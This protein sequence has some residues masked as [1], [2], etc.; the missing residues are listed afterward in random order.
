MKPNKVRE[1]LLV[2]EI[3]T[4]IIPQSLSTL[5]MYAFQYHKI[6]AIIGYGLPRVV[7]IVMEALTYEGMDD[8]PVFQ[9]Q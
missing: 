9:N 1:F 4:N 2:G 8:P 3:N 5:R 7:A 6:A